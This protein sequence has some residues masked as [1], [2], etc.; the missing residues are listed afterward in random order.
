[1]D[2]AFAPGVTDYDRLARKLFTNRPGTTVI[3]KRGMTTVEAFFRHLGTAGM[4]LPADELLVASH[5]ND[6]AWMKIQITGSR[7]G[8][9][10]YEAAEAAARGG[11]TALPNA[12][13]HDAAGALAGTSVNIRG[14]RIGAAPPFVDKLKEAFG[15]ESPVTAPKH[16]HWIQDMGMIGMLE[17][18]KYSFGVISKDPLPDRTAVASALAAESFVY[19]DATSVP[20]DSWAT[21]V[22][23]NVG[24][25]HRESASVYIGLG[26]ALGGLARLRTG[27]EFRHDLSRFTYSISG[28]PRFPPKADRLDTLRA[29]LVTDAGNLGSTFSVSHPFP[30]FQR[31]GHSS[32]DEFVD[33]LVWTFSWDPKKTLMV[34]VGRQHEYT[35]LVPITD[36]PDLTAGNL[37]YNYYPPIG[38]PGAV[39]GLLTSDNTLFYTA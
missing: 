3:Q 25:G 5:G 19:R 27:I 38:A 39:D 10:D 31:Y 34:C 30:M 6:R 13:N 16:F 26:R 18:L 20:A 28:L 21:W 2:Y 23:R 29:A 7:T 11:S 32:L 37:I 15:N 17:F 14:C 9:T 36:P 35:V 33:N 12:V 8:S 22:P 4:S 24:V 1:M